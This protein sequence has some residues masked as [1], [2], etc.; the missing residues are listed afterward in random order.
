MTSET[1]PRASRLTALAA[2]L[3]LPVAGCAMFADETRIANAALA[4]QKAP[5]GPAVALVSAHRRAHGLPPLVHDARLQAL[6]E[7]Q[8]LAMARADRLSHTTAG[9]LASRL[10]GT[11][12]RAAAENISAGYDTLPR[13][14]ESWKRSP[15]HDK[16]LRSAPLRRM[17]IAAADAPGS[18]YGVYWAI[19]MTD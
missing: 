13:A 3:C 11:P 16:N 2:L 8:A 15:E 14:V 17:G 9:S 1:R 19:V 4:P 6:A 7:Q 5:A 18:R 12:H 10:S